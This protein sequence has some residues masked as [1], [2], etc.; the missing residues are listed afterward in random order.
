[1]TPRIAQ[2]VSGVPDG[3]LFEVE[4][5]VSDDAQSGS[6]ALAIQKML[7]GCGISLKVT[8]Q[9]PQEYLRPGPEGPV[10]G[11]S[12]DLAQF[13]WAGAIEPPC[14]LYLSSEIPGPY[15][16]FDK[17]W[18]GVNAS[19]FSNPEFD[20]AC[21]N[22]LFSLADS[23]QH[24]PEHFQAQDIFSEELPA[25]PLYLH[26]T[27]AV[28]RPDLCNYTSQSAMDSPLWNLEGLDYGSGCD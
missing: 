14:Y 4:Y 28:A 3:T 24:L 17:G 18:G 10:F 12:F 9:S 20:L 13:A 2:G 5:L 27:V 1:M 15:L 22:A 7:A 6:D 16:E 8:N 21:E 19:G 11:R 26:Y 23:A 25:L